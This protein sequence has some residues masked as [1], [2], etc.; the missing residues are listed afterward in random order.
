MKFGMPKA[1]RRC[2]A[3]V[4]MLGIAAFPVLG[5]ET[6]DLLAGLSQKLVD[7]RIHQ[8]AISARSYNVLLPTNA[9]PRTLEENATYRCRLALDDRGRSDLS[10][11]MSE[12]PVARTIDHVDLFWALSFLNREGVLVHQMYLGRPYAG[13]STVD[14]IAGGQSGEMR[15]VIVEWLERRIDLKN[16]VLRVS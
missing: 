9:S 6:T 1:M 16:C 8:I 10:A 11:I 14:I 3:I 15:N 7:G 2:V 5:T 13:R 12:R 4:S